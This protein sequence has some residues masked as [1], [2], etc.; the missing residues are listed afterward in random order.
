MLDLPADSWRKS[1]FSGSEGGNCVEVAGVASVVAVRD[2]TDPDGPR[3]AFGRAAFGALARDI[4]AGR[5]D[6]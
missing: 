6:R 2:S 3:L 4:R 1:S 5:Y